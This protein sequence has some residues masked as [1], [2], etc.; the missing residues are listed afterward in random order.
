MVRNL[1]APKRMQVITPPQ[2]LAQPALVALEH[3][4]DQAMLTRMETV[5]I[6]LS[7]L[8]SIDSA[9]LNWLLAAQ[10]RL[11]SQAIQMVLLE[12]SPLC[13]D[14]LTATRLDHRFKVRAKDMAGEVSHA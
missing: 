14:V 6:D 8:Q 7:E 1:E 10:N 9:S 2:N 11:A 4:I 3:Q 12:P 13:L 5:A